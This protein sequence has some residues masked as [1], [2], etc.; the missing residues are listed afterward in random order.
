MASRH[1]SSWKSVNE[2]MCPKKCHLSW[3]DDKNSEKSC[4]YFFFLS[5]IEEKIRAK[6][7]VNSWVGDLGA[8]LAALSSEDMRG[9]KRKCRKRKSFLFDNR[10]LGI[11]LVLFWSRRMSSSIVHSGLKY[12]KIFNPLW[13]IDDNIRQYQKSTKAIPNFLLSKRKLFL[14]LHF[15]FPILSP[16]WVVSHSQRMSQLWFSNQNVGPTSSNYFCTWRI[17]AQKLGFNVIVTISFEISVFVNIF[18]VD[19]SENFGHA[20]GI[21]LLKKFHLNVVECLTQ[22]M[23]NMSCLTLW[24]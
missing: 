8:T 9:R 7:G 13:A 17:K 4:K 10:K 24:T 22:K 12:R 2:K 21:I 1:S 19:W 3:M 5:S 18:W 15:C 6:V 16:L 23:C 14:I 20:I 11:A